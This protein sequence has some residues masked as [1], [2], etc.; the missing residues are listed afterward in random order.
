MTGLR[1]RLGRWGVMA[2]GVALALAIA[3]CAANQGPQAAAPEAAIPVA[4]QAPLPYGPPLSP[5]HY[6]RLVI[7]NTLFRPL[8]DGGTTVIYVAPD[9]SLKLRIQTPSGQISTDVGRE[10]LEPGKVCWL[11]HRAGTTCFHYFWS[12]RLMTFV[13]VGN[14]I[15]PAQFLVQ[16]GNAEGL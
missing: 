1:I 7:G 3:G 2:A 14:R 15:L 8:Q 9:Q 5:L 10:T 4:G 12:G 16:Q 6:H 11:W 13:D